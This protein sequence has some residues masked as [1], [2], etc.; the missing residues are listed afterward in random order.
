MSS[1]LKKSI[2]IAY[3]S[4]RPYHGIA[5]HGK[6]PFTCLINVKKR[7]ST[8]DEVAKARSRVL[9]ITLNS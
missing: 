8:E 6:P 3:Q 5:S 9:L 7:Y 2:I 4:V 1:L